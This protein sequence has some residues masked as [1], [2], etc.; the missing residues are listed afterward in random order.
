M[1]MKKNNHQKKYSG[2][3]A[4]L[5]ILLFNMSLLPPELTAQ[6]KNFKI[7]VTAKKNQYRSFWIVF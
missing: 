4:L 5:I 3:Y 6:N 2:L 7:P 1:T